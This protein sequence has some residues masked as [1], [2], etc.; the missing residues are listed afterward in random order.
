MCAGA[1]HVEFLNLHIPKAAGSSSECT[2]DDRVASDSNHRWPLPALAIRS[3]RPG[4][5][6]SQIGNHATVFDFLR[7][8]PGLP[9][10]LERVQGCSTERASVIY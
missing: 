8:I 10:H 1:E 9:S 3:A 5:T 2:L 7:G 6:L 4:V